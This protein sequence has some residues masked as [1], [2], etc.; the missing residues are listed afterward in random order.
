[1]INE[2]WKQLTRVSKTHISQYEEPM[3][4]LNYI[5]KELE[6]FKEY[7][8]MIS[9]LRSKGLEKRHWQMLSKQL[10]FDIDPQSL[11]LQKLID[12]QLFEGQKL[13]I[14]K[15]VSE[16]AIKE[17]AIK[18]TLDALE[19]ELRIMEFQ[20]MKYKETNTHIVKGMD[21]LIT[22]FEE[23]SIKILALKTNSYA[24]HFMDRIVRVEKELKVIVDV[25]DE[26]VKAQKSWVYLEPIFQ[27]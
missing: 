9:A 11:S 7:M 12:R 2:W 8:P 14:I 16:I 26:W 18:T 21:D 10:G 25:L 1:M 3:T 17:Y 4:L 22:S 19:H 6:K 24:K 20:P 27:Q 13:D 15:G 23:S 5:L